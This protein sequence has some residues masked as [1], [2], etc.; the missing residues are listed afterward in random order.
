MFRR[1]E[2]MPKIKLPDGHE[3]FISDSTIREGA[4][5][6]G[7]VMKKEHKVKIYEFLHE[8]GIEKT[9]TFLYN[10]S[11]RQAVKEMLDL[12][13]KKP[14]V[15]GWARAN[16][17]DIDLVLRMDLPET[18]ILMSVSDAHIFDKI[19]FRSRE[20]AAE[21]YL[22]ALDYALAHGLRVRCHL[23]DITRA[24]IEGFVL[25][26]VKE[27]LER[28]KNVI[29]RIC[30][31]LNY[32]IPFMAEF[33]YSIPKIIVTF[34][35]MGAKNIELHIHD[36]FGMGTTI[37]LAGLWYGAN[38]CNATFLGMGERAGV[39]ELEK[40][41]AFLEFRV[42]GFHKYNLG[43]LSRFA[44]YMEREGGIRIPKNKAVVG[45]NV[46]AH[47]SGIHTDGVLKNPFTYEPFPPELVGAK[48][49][50]I[51]GPTS[52]TSVIKHKVEQILGELLGTNLTL[53]KSD[54]RLKALQDFIKSSYEGGRSSCFSDSELE[55]LVRHF[56]AD[57]LQGDSGV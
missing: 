42:E 39:A 45:E 43:C 19:G 55:T 33:P 1:Y 10:E 7:I 11:D 53:D 17:G 51:I 35:E 31:T 22:K 12:G 21:R 48:R 57:L 40:I 2:D 52:G 56:F 18:G 26:F 50:F 6:P 23:E 13:Y 25:P 49:H 5:M 47:E 16:P 27:I 36:D 54:A 3:V 28:D 14:E 15:T 46:F 38:W 34:K 41:L 20:E 4:Q 24:D 32:G 44:E 30:D 8:I 29:L 9:E 37:S